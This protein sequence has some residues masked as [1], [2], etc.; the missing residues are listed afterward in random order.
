[1]PTSVPPTH[2]K[3]KVP[4]YMDK[5]EAYVAEGPPEPFDV[6]GHQ[7]VVTEGPSLTPEGN[8]RFLVEV[9]HDGNLVKTEEFIIVNPPTKT[10]V[11][12][13]I[14]ENVPAAMQVV[15]ADA[16]RKHLEP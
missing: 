3:K 12:T 1:M 16:V 5:A 14:K 8:V 9:R 6:D 15:L 7:V 11:L 2:R 10:P 13:V 4:T